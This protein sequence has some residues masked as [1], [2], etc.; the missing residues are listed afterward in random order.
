MAP[1]GSRGKPRGSQPVVPLEETTTRMS[2]E[3]LESLRD[4]SERP[5]L[6]LPARPP[7]APPDPPPPEEAPGERQEVTTQAR[8]V[9]GP[10]GVARV[11]DAYEL[12]EETLPRVPSRVLLRKGKPRK[13]RG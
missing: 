8:V 7:F 6:R 3:E 12:D 9:V 4:E 13:K 11:L 5:T 1:R 2:P 10:D